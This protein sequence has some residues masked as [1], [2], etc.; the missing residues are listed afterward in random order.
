MDELSTESETFGRVVS[1]PS[2]W[3]RLGSS[4][5]GM[6][7]PLKKLRSFS[8]AA[9]KVR[10]LDVVKCVKLV[11]S[12]SESF[13]R[14]SSNSVRVWFSVSVKEVTI[15]S[16]RCRATWFV[17]NS[18]FKCIISAVASAALCA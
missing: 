9:S 18:V 6:S 5:S 8:P 1:A 4:Q 14:D 17:D 12:T 11:L 2:F 10:I 3:P 7:I 15:D 16:A 13:N